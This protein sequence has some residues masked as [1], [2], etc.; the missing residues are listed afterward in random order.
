MAAAAVARRPPSSARAVV[1]CASFSSADGAATASDMSGAAL[2]RCD[3]GVSV[4]GSSRGALVR[5]GGELGVTLP[6]GCCRRSACTGSGR[7]EGASRGRCAASPAGLRHRRPPFGR[8]VGR[9]RRLSGHSSWWHRLQAELHLRSWQGHIARHAER[10]WSLVAATLGRGCCVGGCC[11]GREARM[12]AARGEKRCAPS[13]CLRRMQSASAKRVGDGGTSG[14]RES[15]A[16]GR[17][18]V[19]KKCALR[20]WCAAI[21]PPHVNGRMWGLVSRHD[22]HGPWAWDMAM[23]LNRKPRQSIFLA[24]LPVG[25]KSNSNKTARSSVSL[26]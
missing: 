16:T 7:D 5:W 23:A 3:P 25:S 18:E 17:S 10:R 2:G 21:A 13:H 12:A 6:S 4:W 22:R 24:W 15:R 26:I 8:A 20:R 1:S 19:H 9:R 11:V 14:W